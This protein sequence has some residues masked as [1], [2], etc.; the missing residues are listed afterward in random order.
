M[1]NLL[2]LAM[3]SA[4]FFYVGTASAAPQQPGGNGSQGGNASDFD[5][6]E[7]V[8]CGKSQ[9]Y[10]IKKDDGTIECIPYMPSK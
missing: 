9:G 3:L 4:A 7:Y 5:Y 2:P 8:A 6:S 10:A 1:K